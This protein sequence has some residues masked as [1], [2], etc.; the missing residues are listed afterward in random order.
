MTNHE[1]WDP[2]CIVL[3]PRDFDWRDVRQL[4]LAAMAETYS[5]EAITKAMRSQHERS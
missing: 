3:T 4:N 2:G 5:R 1:S